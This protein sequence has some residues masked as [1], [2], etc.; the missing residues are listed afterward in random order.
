MTRPQYRSL[1][2]HIGLCAMN[3]TLMMVCS[4][5]KIASLSPLLSMKDYFTNSIK[6]HACNFEFWLGLNSQ[7]TDLCQ[8]CPICAQHTHQRPQEPFQPYPVPTLPW[9]LVF[10]D[11]FELNG[12]PQSTISSYILRM[13]PLTIKVCCYVTYTFC[14]LLLCN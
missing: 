6:H 7:I 14:N 3:L 5:N 9:Q 10:Q 13:G 4:S 8:S 12:L 11:L 2:N 1:P